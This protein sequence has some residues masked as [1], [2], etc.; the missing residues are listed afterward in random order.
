MPRLSYAKIIIA[1]LAALFL[2]AC[3][4][5]VTESEIKTYDKT[6]TKSLAK[7]TTGL[8]AAELDKSTDRAVSKLRFGPKAKLKRPYFMEFRARSA[9]T[10]GHASIAFGKLDRNGNVPKSKKGVLDPKRV[11][12]TGLHP[13]TTSTVPWSMGHVVPVKA[14]TG[15]SDGD[16]EEKYVTARYRKDLTEA[17]FRKLVAIVHKHKRRYTHWYAP[18]LAS[19][20]LGYI[21]SIAKDMGLKVPSAPELPKQYVKTLKAKNT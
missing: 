3:N 7:T 11:Q 1:F 10:Y 15:P 12:I 14:E 13:A 18:I 17:E 19:N 6:F 2:S 9:H 20:C 16:F 21:S 5:S 4:S 8:K